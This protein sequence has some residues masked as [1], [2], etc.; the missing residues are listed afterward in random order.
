M[1]TTRNTESNFTSTF[2]LS[3]FSSQSITCPIGIQALGPSSTT[4]GIGTERWKYSIQILARPFRDRIFQ[5][6]VPSWRQPA[7]PTIVIEDLSS[8]CQVLYDRSNLHRLIDKIQ[9]VA[10]ET[11]ASLPKN[12]LPKRKARWS[13]GTSRRR[14]TRIDGSPSPTSTIGESKS[15]HVDRSS[16]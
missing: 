8:I 10:S 14:G 3:S 13:S 12:I 16:L 4:S 15:G 1:S 5:E 7:T 2:S 6:C 9:K 11:S